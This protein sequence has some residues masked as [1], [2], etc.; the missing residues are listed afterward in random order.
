MLTTLTRKL[1]PLMTLAIATIGC[2]KKIGEPKDQP[3][4]QTQNQELPS[5]YVIRLDGS[6]SS[7]KNYFMPKDT[8]FKVPDRIIVRSGTTA[9]KIVEIAHDVNIYDSDDFHVKCV[10]NAGII[11]SELV[12]SGC[13]DSNEDDL[14][15]VSEMPFSLRETEIIQIRFKGANSSDM[16]VDAVYSMDWI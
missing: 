1:C 16:V 14:G 6:Q 15:D 2:G 5:A 3:A 11:P 10:Y 7:Y 13:F 8:G 9:G 4:R 12:L